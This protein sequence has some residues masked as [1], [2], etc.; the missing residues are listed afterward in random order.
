MKMEMKHKLILVAVAAAMARTHANDAKTIRDPTGSG[1][2]YD[3][4][5]LQWMAMN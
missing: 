5:V 2:I 4:E 3:Y 1:V